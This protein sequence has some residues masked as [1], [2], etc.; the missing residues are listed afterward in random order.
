MAIF[1]NKTLSVIRQRMFIDGFNNVHSNYTTPYTITPFVTLHS[2]MQ[3]PANQVNAI[4]EFYNANN[5]SFLGGMDASITEAGTSSFTISATTSSVMIND[6]TANWA[7]LWSRRI[8]PENTG[9][10]A[11]LTIESFAD[12]IPPT[13]Q[14]IVVPVSD[15]TTST[16][17]VR[18]NNTNVVADSVT[19]ISEITLTLGMA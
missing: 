19:T 1:N 3:P 15:I 6:G 14:F 8:T 10:L 16:G 9:S 18:V 12:S 4:W 11:T 7:I 13:D 5:T 2:G 17:V